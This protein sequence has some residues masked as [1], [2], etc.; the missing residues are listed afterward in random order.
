M[1]HKS[2]LQAIEHNNPLLLAGISASVSE[3]RGLINFIKEDLINDI[4][5]S[6]NEL[7]EDDK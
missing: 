2:S 4:R 5:D 3:V 7:E 1:Q 6:I